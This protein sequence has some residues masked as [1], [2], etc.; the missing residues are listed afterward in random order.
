MPVCG[1]AVLAQTPV[2]WRAPGETVPADS[3]ISARAVARWSGPAYFCS[4]PRATV[5]A[6][7]AFWRARSSCCEL[8]ATVV[9]TRVSTA[10]VTRINTRKETNRIVI[11]RANP[12]REDGKFGRGESMVFTA[13][14]RRGAVD[15]RAG[16]ANAQ[17]QLSAGDAD[18]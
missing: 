1:L 10:S 8:V 9:S 2:H 12:E 17:T 13:V 15:K 3:S 6:V 4:S 7:S 5:R 11:N 18:K 16:P 14:A